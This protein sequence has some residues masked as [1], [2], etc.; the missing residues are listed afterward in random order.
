MFPPSSTFT[1]RADRA[2]NVSEIGQMGRSVALPVVL[3]H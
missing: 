3:N 1:V 2:K